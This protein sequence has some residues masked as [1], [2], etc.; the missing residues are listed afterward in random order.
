MDLFR[1]PD[2]WLRAPPSRPVTPLFRRT[3]ELVQAELSSAGRIFFCQ[4]SYFDWISAPLCHRISELGEIPPGLSMAGNL[5][6]W[7]RGPSGRYGSRFTTH[8]TPL[9]SSDGSSRNVTEGSA[10]AVKGRSAF[11]Q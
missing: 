4:P 6:L 9:S 3:G 1:S 7:G 8:P 11:Q 10:F 5:L 2:F